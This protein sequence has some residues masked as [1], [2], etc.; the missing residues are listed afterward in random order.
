MN[1]DLKDFI[2]LLLN[3]EIS[4]RMLI[5]DILQT[6]NDVWLDTEDIAELHPLAT[7]L[8]S[9]LEEARTITNTINMFEDLLNDKIE[10]PEFLL[11]YKYRNHLMELIEK[12]EEQEV[13]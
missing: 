7:D 3:D 4:V 8:R 13:A 1:A 9:M 10:K 2:A 11:Q 12:E 5:G 6:M